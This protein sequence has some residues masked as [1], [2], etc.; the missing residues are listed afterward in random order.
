M[1]QGTLRISPQSGAIELHG[2]QDFLRACS[3]L[4]DYVQQRVE[5]PIVLLP[6]R[7]E[8]PQ[9]THE[10]PPGS[11]DTGYAGLP[12]DVE[13]MRQKLKQISHELACQRQQLQQAVHQIPQILEIQRKHLL[14]SPLPK[15]APLNLVAARAIKAPW[16]EQTNHIHQKVLALLQQLPLERF[17]RFDLGL[18]IIYLL[19]SFHRS[20]TISKKEGNV[21]F[22][23]V[24]RGKVS[25]L[26]TYE[27]KRKRWIWEINQ[28]FALTRAGYQQLKNHPV[29]RILQVDSYGRLPNVQHWRLNS[30]E[31][32]QQAVLK[33]YLRLKHPRSSARPSVL[34]L[35]YLTQGFGNTLTVAFP[36][37][38]TLIQQANLSLSSPRKFLHRLGKE[39]YSPVFLKGGETIGLTR[40]G[41]HEL[42]EVYFQPTHDSAEAGTSSSQ[43]H[44]NGMASSYA[45]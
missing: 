7:S 27:L 17:T 3:P 11:L 5:Q 18:L 19:Q 39:P 20:D 40:R 28:Q 2:T 15:E 37:L 32:V 13:S 34:L 43:N 10:T 8:V 21:V 30:A 29:L 41:L 45:W 14:P 38:E 42:Q 1:L 23:Q 26:P 24:Y 33:Q 9:T 35:I 44:H 16:P 25:D 12:P 31:D 4:L 36:L 6:T 22:S